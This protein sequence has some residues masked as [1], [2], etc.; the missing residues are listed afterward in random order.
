M[1]EVLEKYR[2]MQKKLSWIRWAHLGHESE[3]ED[4]LLELM[5]EVWWELS[6]EERQVISAEPSRLDPIT[7]VS[8]DFSLED[9][10]IQTHPGPVRTEAA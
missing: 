2:E 3:E 5:D 7:P 1:S 9:I 6:E 10:D 8:P 4:S